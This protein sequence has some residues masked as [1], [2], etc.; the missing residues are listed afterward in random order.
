MIFGRT[1]NERVEERMQ[2]VNQAYGR[3][4]PEAEQNKDECIHNFEVN[5]KQEQDLFFV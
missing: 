1:G 5:K 3:K 2:K 4:K